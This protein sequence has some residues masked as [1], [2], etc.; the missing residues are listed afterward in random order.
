VIAALID[1][2]G[3]DPA[4]SVRLCCIRL[5]DELHVQTP[6]CRAALQTLQYDRHPGVRTEATMVLANWQ[7]R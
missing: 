5:L 6:A 2:A 4:P 1:T 3:H 7:H